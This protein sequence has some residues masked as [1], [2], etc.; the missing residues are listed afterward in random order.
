MSRADTIFIENMREILDKG[1]SDKDL[2]VRPKWDDGTPAHTIKR[3]GIV[4]RYDLQEEL[5]EGIMELN[6]SIS[7]LIDSLES[8]KSLSFGLFVSSFSYISINLL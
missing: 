4:N 6:L 5:I 2:P 3:F 7:F 8:L 1:F